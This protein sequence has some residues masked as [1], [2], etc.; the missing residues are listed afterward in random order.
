MTARGQD[1]HNVL[2]RL[3]GELKAANLKIELEARARNELEKRHSKLLID[4]EILLDEMTALRRSSSKLTAVDLLS[5]SPTPSTITAAIPRSFRVK[6]R[7]GEPDRNLSVF[8]EI[9]SHSRHILTGIVA[10]RSEEIQN[11]LEVTREATAAAARWRSVALSSMLSNVL[12]SQE[13]RRNLVILERSKDIYK[14]LVKFRVLRESLVNHRLTAV[15]IGIEDRKLL[16]PP[17]PKTTPWYPSGTTS[18]A[19]YHQQRASLSPRCASASPPRTPS[20]GRPP[21]P[22]VLHLSPIPR[23]SSHTS[24]KKTIESMEALLAE[25]R[26]MSPK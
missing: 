19:E 15:S 20:P 9:E 17:R 4:H 6:R 7:E 16:L 5:V 18:S 13:T 21:T 25:L 10:C 24:V 23:D 11:A 26:H 14:M 22:R 2:T 1:L 12:T 8:T 3:T